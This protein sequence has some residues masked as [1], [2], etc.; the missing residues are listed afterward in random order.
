[1]SDPRIVVTQRINVNGY[2]IN[3]TAR[4]GADATMVAETLRHY[5]LAAKW[6][7][8]GH[9]PTDE[10]IAEFSTRT[11]YPRDG[12]THDD[13][14]VV[15]YGEVSVVY[16]E[17]KHTAV[18]SLNKV[19]EETDAITIRN[20]AVALA[21]ATH[22]DTPATNGA[23]SQTLSNP[24]TKP[25]QANDNGGNSSVNTNTIP[26]ILH[27]GKETIVVPL[28]GKASD[29][30]VYPKGT[31]VAFYIHRIE[32]NTQRLNNGTRP[33]AYELY[34]ALPERLKF[35]LIPHR[36]FT[37][38]KALTDNPELLNALQFTL[39]SGTAG[40]VA[41][42]AWM[43]IANVSEYNGKPSYWPIA[44]V[45]A[46]GTPIVAGDTSEPAMQESARYGYS[47]DDIPF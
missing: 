17:G 25:Q 43:F 32:L 22:V 15:C 31:R 4:E 6:L 13:A 45:N 40:S 34:P 42:G 36:I 5:L 14:R 7:G 38:A 33:L 12:I 24:P 29:Y 44:L 9:V 30:P 23:P 20:Y 8:K 11:D 47:P 41:N 27:D 2:Q 10:Q 39:P 3:V 21:H 28:V 35:D 26:P 16:D 1:M 19:T 37:D 18:I 46:D